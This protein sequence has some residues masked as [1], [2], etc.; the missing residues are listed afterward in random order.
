MKKIAQGKHKLGTETTERA[1][2]KRRCIRE[3]DRIWEG[4]MRL[5]PNTRKLP[6]MQVKGLE[7]AATIRAGQRARGI[8][9]HEQSRRLPPALLHGRNEVPAF[10]KE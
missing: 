6:P 2:S 5:H 7:L 8:H 10:Q 4:S 3:E 1:R 9:T